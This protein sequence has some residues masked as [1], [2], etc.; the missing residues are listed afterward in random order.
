MQTAQLRELADEFDAEIAKRD[1]RIEQ[2]ETELKEAK[3][4]LEQADEAHE[5]DSAELVE[6]LTGVKYWLLDFLV[7]HKAPRDPRKILR[8]VEDM[9]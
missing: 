5:G 3:E 8:M 2:L 4:E 1:E 7:H 6:T 9:L